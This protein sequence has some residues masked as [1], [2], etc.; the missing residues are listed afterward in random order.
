M[1]LE[2]FW[3]GNRK[4]HVTF[5]HWRLEDLQTETFCN[6]TEATWLSEHLLHC[7][8]GVSSYQ[9]HIMRQ[10]AQHSFLQLFSVISSMSLTDNVYIVLN[11]FDVCSC[12]YVSFKKIS[13]SW[14]F[15]KLRLLSNFFLNDT[16]IRG[17]LWVIFNSAYNQSRVLFNECSCIS[18][19][20][21]EAK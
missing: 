13:Y 6:Y 12:V 4:L 11:A 9:L 20:I 1:K 2:L 21:L 7:F 15:G 16:S 18:G 8:D 17:L 19:L 3:L 5:Y 10:I 14:T